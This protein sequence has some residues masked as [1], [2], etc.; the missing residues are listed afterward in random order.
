MKIFIVEDD[1]TLA[2]EIAGYLI[3]WGYETRIAENFVDIAKEVSLLSPDL[4][5]M[6]VNLPNYDG[7]YWCEKIRQYSTVP[8]IYI[9]SRNDDRD[10]IMA[11]AWGGDDYVEKPFC[12]E[13][14]KVKVEALLRRTYQYREKR[15]IPL[16]GGLCFDST[17]QIMFIDHREIE[18]TK[19]ER[20]ILA[21]LL[22]E[23][24]NV[25]TREELKMELWSTDEFISDGA[26][27]TALSR[28][29]SKLKE[30]AGGEV[31]CTK[32]GRGYFVP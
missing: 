11:I 12:M 30:A 5:L 4:I 3:K 27:T 32:K 25:V 24:P 21:K 23:R 17:S 1:E 29:R 31:I 14:L 2:G 7:F 6:D 16:W 13:L 28:L 8:I 15:E 9:S 26:L 22:A 19:S 10:K 18:L 20:R